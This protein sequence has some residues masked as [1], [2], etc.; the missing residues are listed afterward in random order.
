[1]GRAGVTGPVPVAYNLVGPGRP[2]G[3]AGA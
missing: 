2:P 1:M 3:P